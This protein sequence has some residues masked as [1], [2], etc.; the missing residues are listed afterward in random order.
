MATLNPQS[1]L[2]YPSVNG[3][4][5][6][7][8]QTRAHETPNSFR[9]AILTPEVK[10]ANVCPFLLS[11]TTVLAELTTGSVSKT[12]I[13]T[14]ARTAGAERAERGQIGAR[15][16]EPSRRGA[17]KRSWSNPHRRATPSRN[18]QPSP[19]RTIS[20]CLIENCSLLIT[21]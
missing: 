1:L 18:V 16:E 5:S 17:R 7:L 12:E 6:S 8:L 2:F 10:G 9:G 19:S 13:G 3:T 15:G 21:A 14:R 20:D 11:A 4:Q